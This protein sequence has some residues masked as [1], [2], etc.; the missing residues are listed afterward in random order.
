[1]SIVPNLDEMT[2]EQKLAVLESVQKS[3]AESKEIQ[4]RKIG[5]NVELV[6]QA[7]K[8]IE[9]DIRSRFDDVGNTIEKRVS[10]IK[11]GRDGQN[12]S[13]GRDGK[14]GK[15]GRDGLQRIQPWRTASRRPGNV[16]RFP[17]FR[18]RSS[19]RERGRHPR[20]SQ[21]RLQRRPLRWEQSRPTR[22]PLDHWARL[23]RG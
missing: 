3:I 7:L 6:V 2:D 21:D 22:Q 15:A 20:V 23:K 13:D 16:R 4:K 5:E 1:M 14:D 17:H 12:G 10:T 19:P 11:D 18:D 9:S 8:K